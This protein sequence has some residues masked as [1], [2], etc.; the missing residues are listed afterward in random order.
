MPKPRVPGGSA[1]AEPVPPA[2]LTDARRNFRN[3]Y[4]TRDGHDLSGLLAEPV[5]PNGPAARRPMTRKT[6]GT[7]IARRDDGRELQLAR[8]RCA[9]AERALEACQRTMMLGRVS[10]ALAHDV[11]N[12]LGV[13][14]N[15]QHL[16]DRLCTDP[17]A[18][19]P[20]AAS[21]RAV[22]RGT[23]LTTLWH[24]LSTARSGD[25][26]PID[27]R[28]FLPAIEELARFIAGRRIQVSL[29]VAPGTSHVAVEPDPLE[30]GLIA[31]LMNAREAMPGGGQIW[32]D[33]RNAEA[34]DDPAAAGHVAVTV[35]DD[36]TGMGS[37]QVSRAFEPYHTTRSARGACGLGLAQVKAFCEAAGGTARLASTVGLGTAVTMLLPAADD[38]PD[39]VCSDTATEDPAP[40]ALD[41]STSQAGTRLLLVEDS[42]DMAE[43]TS[44]LL[45]RHGFRVQ[46]ARDA[47]EAWRVLERDNRF[48]IVLSDVVMPGSSDGVALARRVARRWPALP[49]VLISGQFS[50]QAAGDLRV[51]RK[52]CAPDLLVATLRRAMAYGRT[53]EV[54]R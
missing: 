10:S 9:A 13:I 25:G 24:R 3:P 41:G 22:Q 14:S 27:L 49:V 46:W 7:T 15:S 18:Q 40:P 50:G 6:R 19:T 45:Q 17:A 37:D 54:A 38:G 42:R 51:L 44:A 30:L 31:L 34:G 29:H 48:G 36:G 11:N 4:R 12:L 47:D 26:L 52:P 39:P 2:P 1:I 20:L 23:R 35:T 8:E 21:A 43:V 53:P 28:N 16:L 32:I 5:T 33:A